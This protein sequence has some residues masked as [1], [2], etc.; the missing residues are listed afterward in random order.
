ML[1]IVWYILRIVSLIVNSDIFR[2]IHVL[3]RHVQL[4]FG[5]FRI[6]CNSC[7]FKTQPYW[8][9]WHIDNTRYIQNSVKADSGI[10]RTLCNGRYWEPFHK[11][12]FCI[13][14]SQAYSESSLFRHIQVY[15]GTFNNDKTFFF[16]SFNLHTF[17]RNLFLDYND[18]NFNAWLSLCKQYAIFKKSVAIE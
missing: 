5:I 4:Y 11:Q 8:E 2:H 13:F 6:L 14:R 15:S 3:F 16:F 1:R 9:S 7:I 10:F 12:N 17:Q 18:V